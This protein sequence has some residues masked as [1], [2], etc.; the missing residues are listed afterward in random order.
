[1]AKQK[2]KKKR[3]VKKPQ[4]LPRSVKALLGYL[5]GTD[6][7]IGGSGPQRAQVAPQILIS[8]QQTINQPSQFIPREKPVGQIIASS[9]LQK[10]IP[11]R[12]QLPYIAPQPQQQP[13]QP[14]IISKQDEDK[15]ISSQLAVLNK[16][17]AEASDITKVLA[18]KAINLDNR[19]IAVNKQRFAETSDRNMLDSSI[20]AGLRNI[21]ERERY[22]E[23]VPSRSQ[24]VPSRPRITAA[25]LDIDLGQ[26][27]ASQYIENVSNPQLTPKETIK[28]G[29]PKLSEEQKKIN[30]EQRRLM[31]LQEGQSAVQ[32]LSSLT[33]GMIKKTAPKKTGK[34][35]QLIEGVDPSTQISALIGGG[36]AAQSRGISLEELKK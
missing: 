19:I 6:V 11:P 9:P 30:A 33:S 7:K 5:G 31:K 14:I 35:G 24:S 29:R 28:R 16:K 1:M 13:V 21:N 3:V 15:S 36:Q 10:I 32:A 27:M 8:Q 4:P 26:S 20:P 34:S 12:P 18:V 2:Q 25:D 23:D 22:L 17:V